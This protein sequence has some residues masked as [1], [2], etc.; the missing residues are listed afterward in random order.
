[1][2]RFLNCA[3]DCLVKAVGYWAA[4]ALLAFI[5]LVAAGLFTASGGTIAGL[6]GLGAAAITEIL[7]AA[8][9]TA[10]KLGGAAGL[11]T[12]IGCVVQC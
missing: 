10:A 7:A 2:R 1:M 3:W 9:I 6:T 8:G 11:G 12:F 5:V 4:V